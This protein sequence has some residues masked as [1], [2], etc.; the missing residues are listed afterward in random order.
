MY[1][2]TFAL[3]IF[4]NIVVILGYIFC[5]PV[6]KSTNVYLFNLSVSDFIFQ[7]TLPQLAYFYAYNLKSMNPVECI[8]DRTISYTNLYSTILFMMW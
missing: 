2:L 5:L 3:G 6:W 7:C 4:G 1:A 8:I